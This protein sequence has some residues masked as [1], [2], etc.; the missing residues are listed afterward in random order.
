MEKDSTL[1]DAEVH[2]L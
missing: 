1:Y 2:I